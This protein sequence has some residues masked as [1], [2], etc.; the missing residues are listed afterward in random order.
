MS[1]ETLDA[2]QTGVSEPEEAHALQ[3][4]ARELAM[5]AIANQNLKRLEEET[6]VKLIDAEDEDEDNDEL[7][8]QLADQL[9]DPAPAN[10]EVRKVKVDGV[11][12]EVTDDELIRT[13][14]KNAAADSR[15]E[16][17]TRLLREAEARA[18]QIAAQTAPPVAP[19]VQKEAEPTADEDADIAP[20]TKDALE[21]LLE[22]DTES[23]AKVL[24]E[25]MAK[26]R[27]GDQPTPSAPQLDVDQVAAQ[28]EAR[29]AIA[30]AVQKVKTDY[31]EVVSDPD[32]EFLTARKVDAKVQGGMPRAEAILEA[33]KETYERFGFGKGR[34]E[35]EPAKPSER[36]LRKQQLEQLPVASSSAAAPQEQSD[37]SDPSS[38][39]RQMAARRLGQSL[40][41]G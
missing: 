22:G 37:A 26:K 41:A 28:V 38:I 19:V 33:A 5:E 30:N 1:K 2:T 18:A 3:P 27:G 36:T 11:E 12:R 6:G 4:S 23:A 15:L 13:Y 10:S 35:P 7:E 40:P 21:K 16:E 24:T 25:L 34:Q 39:I 32:I 14:Q 9:S 8:S 20:K 29:L 17:A 31:P